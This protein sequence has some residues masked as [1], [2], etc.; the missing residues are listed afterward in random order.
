[1]NA[2][3]KPEIFRFAEILRESMTIG[4]RN[5]WGFLYNRPLGKKFRRQHPFGPY[6]MD[7]YCHSARLSIEIDGANHNKLHQKKLDA[8]R[9][10]YIKSFGIIELRFTDDEVIDNIE[11][12]IEQIKNAIAARNPLGS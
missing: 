2:N 3:A 4:E 10:Q 6:I 1:M 5:I 9:T 7:F 11:D 8:V 12:V